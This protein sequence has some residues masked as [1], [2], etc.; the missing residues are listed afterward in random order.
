MGA[1]VSIRG[2]LFD[3]DGTLIEVNDTWLPIYRR[4]LS[5]LFA[6][7]TEGVNA[8][9]AKLAT[10]RITTPDGGASSPRASELTGKTYTFEANEAKAETITCQFGA[11]KTQIELV[12]GGTTHRIECGV[13]GA[14]ITQS[15][16]IAIPYR[17]P[18]ANVAV[19]G[20][21]TDD[22]TFV[23]KLCFY[24]M[25]FCPILTFHFE[26]NSVT[27]DNLPNV[28]FG[29]PPPPQLVGRC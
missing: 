9:A 6:A 25:P 13:E 22:S 8:L 12:Q 7:N 14:W 19:S 26:G 18:Q 16:G 4:I 11:D 15:T 28:S 27:F 21:W 23:A 24:E 1:G 10:L 3:K 5:D 29:T 2:I 20:A 17:L